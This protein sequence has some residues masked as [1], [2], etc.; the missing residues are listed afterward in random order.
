MTSYAEKSLVPEFLWLNGKEPKKSMGR[1]NCTTFL[2]H[3]EVLQGWELRSLDLP[4]N[5]E[6]P[7]CF[8]RGSKVKL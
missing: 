2:D 3:P 1:S 6:V 8:R 7:A 5:F 4:A